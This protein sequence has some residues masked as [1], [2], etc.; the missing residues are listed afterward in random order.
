[1]LDKLAS[2]EA[3]YEELERLLSDPGMMNDY[4]KIA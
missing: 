3:R 2:I 4:T 1:M